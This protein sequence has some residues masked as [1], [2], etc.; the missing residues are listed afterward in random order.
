MPELPEV[1]TIART[2]ASEV[3]S[4]LILGVEVLDESAIAPE[5]GSFRERVLGRRIAR[6]DR[7]GKLLLLHLQAAGGKDG[8][9][10]AVH[11]RMTGRVLALP[12]GESP[13]RPRVVLTLSDR[14]CGAMLLVFSDVRRF[15]RMHAFA[16]GGGP[17]SIDHWP[18]Y[19]DL[20]PEPLLITAEEFRQRLAPRGKKSKAR[21]KALL[22]DQGVIAGIGNI[23]AD[24]ALLRAGIRPDAVAGAVSARRQD[25]LFAAIQ[26]V[27]TQAI[28]ENGSSIRDY[29]DAHGDAGSFQNHFQAYGRAG[30]PC[31]T[32]GAA[33]RSL[34]VAGRTSTFCPHCQTA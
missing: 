23:Y 25:R 9:E 3:E 4:R 5:P 11:L 26:A 30:Q 29:R 16:P 32:C 24:E 22:L 17:D 34:R 14:G 2:L 15:G 33:L 12:P 18:F 6:V 28:A 1:E 20:G 7:R 31:L 27:L 10:I 21:I 13:V 8:G 19:R